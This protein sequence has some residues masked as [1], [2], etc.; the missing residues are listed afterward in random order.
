[1]IAEITAGEYSS[2]SPSVTAIAIHATAFTQSP[3]QGSYYAPGNY[4]D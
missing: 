1:V 3:Q 4:M 2:A